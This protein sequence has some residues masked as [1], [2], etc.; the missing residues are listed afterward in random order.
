MKASSSGSGR[1]V[2]HNTGALMEELA[3]RAEELLNR[4]LSMAKEWMPYPPEGVR[5]QTLP[6]S[7][8]DECTRSA[9]HINLLTEDN[10]PYYARATG[11]FVDHLGKARDVFDAWFN[12]WIAE[13]ARHSI[14]IRNYVVATASVDLTELEQARLR[15][16]SAGWDRNI[17]NHVDLLVYAALQELATRIAHRNTAIRLNSWG[18]ELLLKV[19]SDENLHHLFYRDLCYTASRLDPSSFLIAL[20]NQIRHFEMPGTTIPEFRRHA[21]AIA[22]AQIYD[23]DIHVRH[24][25]EPLVDRHWRTQDLTGLSTEAELARERLSRYMARLRQV[26][27]RMHIQSHDA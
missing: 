27:E 24:V 15:T 3:P 1:A 18:R 10:L 22:S 19:A 4:H 25:V 6:P 21:V 9:L 14:A 11:R 7:S 2:D 8:L 16:M 13:E 17:G 26:S 20:D 23:L 5:H 12:R